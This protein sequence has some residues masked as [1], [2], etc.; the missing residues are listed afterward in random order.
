[1]HEVKKRLSVIPEV[2]YSTHTQNGILNAIPGSQQ[3]HQTV[4]TAHLIKAR[5][6]NKPATLFILASKKIAVHF[7]ILSVK[8]LPKDVSMLLFGT[9][10]LSRDISICH[11]V[12]QAVVVNIDM[13]TVRRPRGLSARA[14]PPWLFS[15]TLISILKDSLSGSTKSSTPSQTKPPLRHV[16]SQCTLP[17]LCTP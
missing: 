10:V 5:K 13:L 11:Q 17:Q 7:K 2:V 9:D 14:F 3:I 4:S 1:M 8:G 16:P 12:T 6:L 15:K